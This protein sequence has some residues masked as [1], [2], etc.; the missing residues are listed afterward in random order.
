MP[1]AAEAAAGYAHR[2]WRAAQGEKAAYWFE[3]ARR[4]EPRD[5][6][7]HWYAGQFWFTQASLSRKSAAARLADEAFSQGYEANPREFRNLLGRI[8][9]H[10]ELRELLDKPA[11]VA[12]LWRWTDRAVELAPSDPRTLMEHALVLKQFG[13][14]RKEIAK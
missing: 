11:D 7:Y 10:R 8:D 3:V 12:T 14:P 1:V 2:Q 4:I 6:R 5:W 9:V 13:T